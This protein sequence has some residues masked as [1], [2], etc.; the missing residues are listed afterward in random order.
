MDG[1]GRFL[2]ACVRGSL[3]GWLAGIVN[4]FFPTSAHA[5]NPLSLIAKPEPGDGTFR[6]SCELRNQDVRSVEI[7]AFKITEVSPWQFELRGKRQPGLGDGKKSKIVPY[8]VFDAMSSSKGRMLLILPEEKAMSRMPPWHDAK[9]V[10]LIAPGGS[11]PFFLDFPER[12]T[13]VVLTYYLRR[14]S[15]ELTRCRLTKQF[16]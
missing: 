12:P 11:V 9:D 10:C 14:G 6:Y 5:G 16:P 3:L 13:R 15:G 1:M 8:L 4:I 2:P 7:L